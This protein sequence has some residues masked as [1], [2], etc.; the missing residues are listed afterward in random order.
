MRVLVVDDEPIVLK[1]CRMVLEAEG[2]RGADGRLG[3]RRP[4]RLIEAQAP[5]CCW[6]TSRC[7]CRT[8]CISCARSRRD[9][10]GCPSSS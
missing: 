6:S 10:R 7:R 1:S 2:L 8:A 5:G 4:W 9:G 3:R